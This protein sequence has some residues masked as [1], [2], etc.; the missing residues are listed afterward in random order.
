M[1]HRENGVHFHHRETAELSVTT[2]CTFLREFSSAW[3]ASSGNPVT[4]A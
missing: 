3:P 1:R 4:D 2:F